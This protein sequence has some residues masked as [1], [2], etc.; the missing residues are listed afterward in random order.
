LPS[1]VKIVGVPVTLIFWPRATFLSMALVSQPAAAAAG[2]LPPTIQSFQ[3]A[4]LSLAHQ[5]FFDFSVESGLRMGYR[6]V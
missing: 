3:A 2:A 1:A 4:A 5:M 6:K